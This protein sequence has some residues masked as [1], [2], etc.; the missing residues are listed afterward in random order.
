MFERL[1][2]LG[3]QVPIQTFPVAP[4]RQVIP[5]AE[6]AQHFVE[7]LS[8]IIESGSPEE[9]AKKKLQLALLQKQ[10]AQIPLDAQL[11][12][13]VFE[14]S[15]DTS[16][17]DTTEVYGPGG[18]H[19][20]VKPVSPEWKAAGGA[21]PQQPQASTILPPEPGTE[22]ITPALSPSFT[23]PNPP[24]PTGGGAGPV[25]PPIIAPQPLAN[26]PDLTDPGAAKTTTVSPELRAATP[27]LPPGFTYLGENP[28][29]HQHYA[30]APDG[31]RVVVSPQPTPA[32]QT[33]APGGGSATS[34]VSTTAGPE[35]IVPNFDEPPT[36][37]PGYRVQK[38]GNDWR[39]INRQGHSYVIPNKWQRTTEVDSQNITHEVWVN[40][41]DPRQRYYPPGQTKPTPV[42]P[43]SQIVNQIQRQENTST[44]LRTYTSAI[45]RYSQLIDNVTKPFSERTAVDDEALI[46][47]HA[48][49]ETPGQAITNEQLKLV[50]DTMGIGEKFDVWRSKFAG[51]PAQGV[52]DNLFGKKA[53]GTYQKPR[54]LSDDAVRN[55]ASRDHQT[56]D[57]IRKNTVAA[58]NPFLARADAY[59]VPVDQ[60]VGLDPR[61]P[62]P[63]LE[64]GSG[65]KP[66]FKIPAPSAEPAKGNDPFKTGMIYPDGRGNRA[67]Y[68][69]NGHWQPMP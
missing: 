45:N 19:L 65:K 12:R 42:S 5:T 18:V 40:T 38:F 3:V 17:F 46:K 58:L 21:L 54:L 27:Q 59:K 55:I 2:G 26:V 52:L 25:E 43:A 35:S 33:A 56:V 4:P 22:N 13:Q 64:A 11:Q 14:H 8:K 67:K 23:G 44:Q 57:E 41:S 61:Q 28:N 60:V 68:L 39:A 9:K 16:N 62:L 66:A 50:H 53:D 1:P 47:A 24:L 10:L 31:T 48:G 34:A 6:I 37:P 69:G 7:G 30:Q 36:V 32:I 49:I 63:P 20:E 29:D 51:T 15:K